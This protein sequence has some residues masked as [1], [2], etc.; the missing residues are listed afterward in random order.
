MS[1]IELEA[2]KY[3]SCYAMP[4]YRT[5]RDRLRELRLRAKDI[6]PG[7]SYLDVSCGRG[8]SLLVVR[9]VQPKAV[10]H[11]TEFTATCLSE[12]R[13]V[14]YGHLPSLEGVQKHDFVSCLD[15]LEHVP[16]HDLLPSIKRLLEL[17]SRQLWI[18]TTDH[19]SRLVEYDGTVQP[20]HLSRLPLLW[21]MNTLDGLAAE[22]NAT[23]TYKQLKPHQPTRHRWW[24]CIDMEKAYAGS[25]DA[26]GEY[27]RQRE[28]QGYPADQLPYHF[29]YHSEFPI[30]ALFPTN[31]N[32]E[33]R[34]KPEV[35]ALAADIAARGVQNPILVHNL[36]ERPD[37][38]YWVRDGNHRVKAAQQAGLT[39]I[40]AII[41][42]CSEYQQSPTGKKSDRE[43]LPYTLAQVNGLLCDGRISMAGPHAPHME[44]VMDWKAGEYPTRAV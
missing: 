12:A 44:A 7:D 18:S 40:P 21:W 43:L 19:Y 36:P 5:G 38:P 2:S 4:N 42:G 13:G 10:V 25:W 17:T 26:L 28:A 20:L 24:F 14:S 31:W 9:E 15:V 3:L 30:E 27:G 6:R 16:T 11:G 39:T 8:E 34:A 33:E 22:A 1:S 37:R 23:L 32:P 35:Q 41:Y 29:W